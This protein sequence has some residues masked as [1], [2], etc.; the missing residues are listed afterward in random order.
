MR[1]EPLSQRT[2]TSPEKP[3]AFGDRSRLCVALGRILH[4]VPDWTAGA[5]DAGESEGPPSGLVGLWQNKSSWD[6]EQD[7][8]MRPAALGEF[9]D[10]LPADRNAAPLA[11]IGDVPAELAD[12]VRAPLPVFPKRKSDQERVEPLPTPLEPAP[13]CV[14]RTD[15]HPPHSAYPSFLV[16]GTEETSQ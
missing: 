12:A 13:C 1:D 7:V 6:P 10:P 2:T 8:V 16:Q 3:C 15:H 14:R 5:L 9:E 11:E 4:Q